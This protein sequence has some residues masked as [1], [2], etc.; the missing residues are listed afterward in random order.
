VQAV[1]P[2]QADRLRDRPAV[3]RGL[4]HQQPA[5]VQQAVRPQVAAPVDRREVRREL[6]ECRFHQL[7]IYTGGAG[8]PVFS[9]SH[10]NMITGQ[11]AAV[12]LAMPEVPPQSLLRKVYDAT[13]G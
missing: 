6:G 7:G 5:H 1:R 3:A 4:R 13:S 9:L 10:T 12:R 11:L 2:I 8:R